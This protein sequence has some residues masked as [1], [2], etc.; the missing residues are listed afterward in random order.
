MKVY[1][2]TKDV[3]EAAFATATGRI[4]RKLGYKNVRVDFD[5]NNPGE[6]KASFVNKS[7]D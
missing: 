7:Y 2:K 6:V 1:N 3:N 4:A 5:P